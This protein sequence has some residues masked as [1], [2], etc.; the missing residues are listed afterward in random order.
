MLLVGDYIYIR[1]VEPQ[2]YEPLGNN[3]VHNSE[4]FITLKLYHHN[5]IIHNIDLLQYS[6]TIV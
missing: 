2:S 1:T 3:S 6:N 4:M 5:D